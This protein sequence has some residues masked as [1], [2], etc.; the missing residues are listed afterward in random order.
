MLSHSRLRTPPPQIAPRWLTTSTPQRT[1]PRIQSQ[2]HPI[3]LPRPTQ[4]PFTST[5][6]S[7]LRTSTK[8][9]YHQRPNYNRFSGSQRTSLF[10]TLLTK[11]KPHHFVLI[12][13]GISGLYLYNTDV[14][15]MTG[16]RRFNCI[17]AEREL[18]MGAE[19]YREVLASERGKVLPD[20]H[21][22]TKSVDRVL[23]RLIPMA[24]IEGAEWKVH[25]IK[26]DG[27][28]N[29]F[30][31]PGGKVFVYTGI[32]PICQDENG[33]AAVLGHEIAHVV[34]RHPA[35]R[36]STSFLTLGTVFL[37]SML[38][39]VSGQLSSMM[40]NLMWSLPNSRTQEAEADHMGLMMMAKACFDPS[41]AVRLWHRMQM[42]EKG[43][44]LQFMSTHPSS[45]NREEA[46][47]GWLER[48]EGVYLDSD[49]GVVGGFVPGFR[50]AV[51]ENRSVVW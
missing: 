20:S 30:V 1:S 42:Q 46:I 11:S 43:V 49:C 5:P 15:E 2:L 32:L 38:F 28:A 29:A 10:R 19:S 45:Y 44:P 18:A 37:V 6:I 34:A 47:R 13:I 17:S 51:R 24:D 4:R 33:L 25:V 12:G 23:Q 14:V 7:R 40:V 21:P 35:E 22:L 26:D 48:A 36:M 27:N 41:A 31:L 50:S 8:S 9:S 16:R 39:D 3:T